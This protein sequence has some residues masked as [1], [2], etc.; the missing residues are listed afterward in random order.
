MIK[1]QQYLSFMGHILGNGRPGLQTGTVPRDV[2]MISSQKT[3]G[4]LFCQS[5]VNRANHHLRSGIGK[6]GGQVFLRLLKGQHLNLKDWPYLILS[7]DLQ[8]GQRSIKET[9]YEKTSGWF[10][11][12]SSGATF[13]RLCELTVALTAVSASILA[14]YN[15]LFVISIHQQK[16]VATTEQLFLSRWGR[17]SA[18]LHLKDENF[19]NKARKILRNPKCQIKCVITAA[20]EC[21]TAAVAAA[22]AEGQKDEHAADIMVKKIQ[23]LSI[24]H[25]DWT[26]VHRDVSSFQNDSCEQ[27]GLCALRYPHSS[28]E[29]LGGFTFSPSVTGVNVEAASSNSSCLLA[30]RPVSRPASGSLTGL[31]CLTG[32]IGSSYLMANFIQC[33]LRNHILF[34]WPF[35]PLPLR[36]RAHCEPMVWE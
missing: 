3:E 11:T 5:K 10:R 28:S 1:I 13:A 36:E 17:L 30:V 23:Y 6:S 9:E 22:N 20:N 26:C 35:R 14:A 24:K 18:P 34:D 21:Q 16:I 31:V 29:P 19:H 25:A 33:R 8:S 27:A 12:S 15:R 7:I 4:G 2:T 32:V